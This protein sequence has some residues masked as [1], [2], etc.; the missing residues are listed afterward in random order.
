MQV[1]SVISYCTNDY[2]LLKRCISEALKFSDQVIVTV[3]DHFFNG[4]KENEYLLKLTFQENPKVQFVQF[5]YYPDRLY[6]KLV[7]SEQGDDQWNLC[8]H[9]TSRYIGFFFAK[10]D[11]ILFLDSDEIVDGEKFS[12]WLKE[13]DYK[14]YHAMRFA[15][16]YY[17]RY[18]HLQSRKIYRSPLMVKKES[19]DPLMA[20]SYEDRAGIY[21]RIEGEKHQK[22]CGQDSL[23]MFHHYSWVKTQEECLKKTASWGHWWEKDWK[24]LVKEEFSREFNGKDFAFDDEY[25]TVEP[26][27]DPLKVKT[28]INKKLDEHF[29]NVTYVNHTDVTKMSLAYEFDL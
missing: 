4:E 18:A 23:P 11:L 6:N 8:W 17:F 26:F 2:R 21:R 3:C 12:L 1:T 9:G 5:A 29:S 27:F 16:Y 24:A 19:M 14:K 13:K 22:I 25:V 20:L 15:C 7:S 28:P 10:N